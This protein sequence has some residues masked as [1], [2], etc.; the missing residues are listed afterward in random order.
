[1]SLTPSDDE[2]KAMYSDGYF[3]DG[4]AWVCGFWQGGYI[5]NEQNLR[6]E[7]R[8]ALIEVGLPSKGDSRL[9]EIGAAGGFFLDEARRVGYDVVG[10]ELNSS[11]AA[12]AR[13]RLGLDVRSELF[14]NA[15]FELQSFDVIVAQD[16]LEHVRDLRLFVRRVAYLLRPG[17]VF[18]VR[19][20][21]EESLRE[22]MYLTIRK[23]VRR[24]VLV[25]REPPY[26]LQGFCRASFESLL[27]AAG[28]AVAGFR[29]TS[30]RPQR[31]WHSGKQAVATTVEVFAHFADLIRGGGE[32]MTARATK[33]PVAGRSNP[34]EAATPS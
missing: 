8:A 29:A 25:R 13:Q 12:F 20:P 9:L 11:M 2:L 14:E 18:F 22:A 17:G 1:V 3:S 28:L 26:H 5:D 23:Y 19:G 27:G 24:Q 4:G 32:F 15:V 16:V 6:R 31:H 21:L 34:L 7:A 33:D 10:I 30:P